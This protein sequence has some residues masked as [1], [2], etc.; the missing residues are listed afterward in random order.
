MRDIH[1]QH[2]AQ[3]SYCYY[4]LLLNFSVAAVGHLQEAIINSTVGKKYLNVIYVHSCMEKDI[5][6]VFIFTHCHITWRRILT[7]MMW[8]NTCK[9]RTIEVTLILGTD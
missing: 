5:K 9:L 8:K 4:L 2:F 7:C 6:F 1:Y 3:C